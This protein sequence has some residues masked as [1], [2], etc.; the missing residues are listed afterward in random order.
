MGPLDDDCDG[1]ASEP[2]SLRYGLDCDCPDAGHRAA[3]EWLGRPAAGGGGD[4][5]ELCVLERSDRGHSAA[6]IRVMGLLWSDV[7]AEARRC[8][9]RRRSTLSNPPT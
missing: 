6:A 5:P 9:S 7:D 2:E 8:E 1:P 3:A 4:V